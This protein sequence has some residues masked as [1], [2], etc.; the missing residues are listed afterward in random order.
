MFAIQRH[1]IVCLAVW[2]C[3]FVASC[4]AQPTQPLR[5]TVSIPPKVEK[6][7]APEP[8]LASNPLIG[9][10]KSNSELTLASLST[11]DGISDDSREYLKQNV[12]GLLTREFTAT[13][14]R[15]YFGRI[16][17]GEP[18]SSYQPYRILESNDNKIVIE[19]TD[20]LTGKRTVSTLYPEN[21]C[22]YELVSKW[23]Y[24]EYFC[25]EQAGRKKIF[26]AVPKN[27]QKLL[28]NTQ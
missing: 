6:V 27:N 26:I 15:T 2:S 24:K 21:N 28:Q 10:W 14:V 12:F 13:E 25:R 3:A 7:V 5:P 19:H 17:E 22:Y 11:T 23:Q 1:K 20:P 16:K 18:G 9:V 8:A 4:Q